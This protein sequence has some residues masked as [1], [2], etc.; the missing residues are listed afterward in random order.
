MQAFNPSTGAII[1]TYTT[2]GNAAIE[3]VP[4]IDNLGRLYFGDTSGMF[5][6]LNTDGTEAYTPLSLGTSITSPVAIQSD[7]KIYV[8]VETASG[9]KLSALTTS[10]TSLQIGGWPMFGKNAKHTSNVNPVTL[11]TSINA[12]E[13]FSVYPN[14]VNR[15][16]FS[17]KTS[18]HKNLDIQIFDVLGKQ[19]Y[20]KNIKANEKIQVADLKAGLYILKVV[21]D[22][23][24]ST[25][26]LFIK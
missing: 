17:I 21:E 24:L 16:E 13:G 7:G 25:T 4:A 20:I 12:I 1:W 23:K 8:G 26:K 6:V 22:N 11:S 18:L 19:V 14:P 15:G 2:G 9:G 10:A 3:V 5:Y